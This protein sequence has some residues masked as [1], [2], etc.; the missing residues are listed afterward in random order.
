MSAEI[1]NKR[2]TCELV[3]I[4]SKKSF[5]ELTGEIERLFQRYDPDKL[6]DLTAAGDAAKLAAYAKQIGEPTGFGIFYQLDMGSI[7]RLAGIP[8]ESSF[9]LFGNATTGQELFRHSGT[10]GLGAPTGFCVSQRDGEETRID[11]DLPTSFFSQ[12]PELSASPV[13]A[14]LGARMIPLLQSVAS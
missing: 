5:V 1:T 6:R 12:F 14:Q 10:A 9:Y 8:I 7:M 4:R 2:F 11:I 3:T 13:P